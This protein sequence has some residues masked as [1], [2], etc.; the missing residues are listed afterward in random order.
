MH[1]LSIHSSDIDPKIDKRKNDLI[2]KML[3]MLQGFSPNLLQLHNE[4]HPRYFGPFA[5]VFLSGQHP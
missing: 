3:L 2:R 4:G 5:G 1:L